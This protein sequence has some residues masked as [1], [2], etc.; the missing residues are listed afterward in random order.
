MKFRSILCVLLIG[1]VP[2]AAAAKTPTLQ[3]RIEA[4]R[5]KA[6]AIQARLHA[7]RAQLNAATVKVQ[8]LQSQLNETN[9]AIGQVSAQLDQLNAAQHSTQRKADWN[10][11]QLRAAE[12][13]FKLHDQVLRQRLV[14]IYE[15]GNLNYLSVLLSARSFT[16]FV[17]RWEDLHLL[18]S[19]NEDAVRERRAAAEH[20]AAIQ[21]ELQ[22][23][24]LELNGEAQD[25][26]RARNQLDALADE[27]RNLVAVADNQRRHVASEVAEMEDLS[28]AE[29]AQLESLIQE[30]ARALAAQRKAEGIVGNE[31]Q[32]SAPGAFAWPVSGTITSPFGWRSNPF[33]GAPEFHQGLDIA[34][35]T[36]TTITASAGGTVIM[37]QW[38]GGYGNYILIDDGGGYSTGYGHLSA[39]YVSAG[40]QVKQGQAIGA[41]GC[42]GECTGPHVHFEIRVNGKPVDP[43]PRLRS[44]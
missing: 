39:F 5:Q 23:T 19:A 34:A 41:V 33:G 6:A 36:G 13:S 38:Y 4:Q 12:Q 3:Q 14:E 16:E 40:Q 28:A 21:E 8:G 29:E 20:V 32:T 42:T 22:R 44:P 24:Q 25:Q 35:P 31:V 15:N 26:Q 11:V 7:K 2:V 18:I 17:E 10:G 9:T 30:R 37:A 43:A 27:R 1:A